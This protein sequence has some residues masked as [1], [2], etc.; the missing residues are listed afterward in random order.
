MSERDLSSSFLNPI[1]NSLNRRIVLKGVAVVAGSAASFSAFQKSVIAQPADIPFDMEEIEVY[2]SDTAEIVRELNKRVAR[3]TADVA[4]GIGNFAMG[5]GGVLGAAGGAAAAV[6]EPTGATKGLAFVLVLDGAVML[7][8]GFMLYWLAALLRWIAADPPRF[9][10]TVDHKFTAS[11]FVDDI[12]NLEDSTDKNLLSD[13]EGLCRTVK[14]IWDHLEWWQAAKAEADAKWM[15]FHARKFWASVDDLPDYL[16][17]L[18]FNLKTTVNGLNKRADLLNKSNVFEAVAEFSG[19][20]LTDI[21]RLR[22]VAEFV[23]WDSRYFE[24]GA[25]LAVRTLINDDVVASMTEAQFEA[26][27]NKLHESADYFASI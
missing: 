1:S 23:N 6:P 7:L 4:M 25:D 22:R 2:A 11:F 26:S 17:A 15:D 8:E 9:P 3:E 20:K 21:P 24:R 14:S 19:R 18:S 10:Y 5:L 16:R 13:T 12:D 27:L